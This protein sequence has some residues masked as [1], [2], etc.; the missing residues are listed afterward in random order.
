MYSQKY[1][2]F[3][4]IAQD[5]YEFSLFLYV[6]SSLWWSENCLP[7]Y[8]IYLLIWLKSPPLPI[9]PY[10]VFCCRRCLFLHMSALSSL[11]GLW[12]PVGGYLCSIPCRY[13]LHPVCAHTPRA[14]LPILP[15]PPH[16][17]FPT[18]WES[19][20]PELEHSAWPVLVCGHSLPPHWTP[21]NHARMP[22]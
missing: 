19:S 17:Y 21:M 5:L 4:T 18:V 14:W 13:N 1:F 9:A 3:N 11:L 12:R 15:A 8:W 10:P 2:N 22:S 6:Y 7:L 16:S 20:L